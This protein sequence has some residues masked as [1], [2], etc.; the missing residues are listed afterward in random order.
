MA[1]IYHDILVNPWLWF[2]SIS[3]IILIGAYI[4]NLIIRGILYLFERRLEKRS[5]VI[6]IIYNSIKAPTKLSV[7][8]LAAWLIA[9]QYIKVDDI[10]F[11]KITDP[12]VLIMKLGFAVAFMWA[13]FRFANQLRDYYIDK[14]RRTDGGY[15]DFSLI[16]ALHKMG[17][18]AVTVV[19]FF[20]FMSIL[21]IPLGSL[22]VVS[23]AAIAFF[24]FSQQALIQNLFGGL[25]LYLDRPFSEGDWITAM[26][27]SF[28]GTVDKVSFRITRFI[29]FDSRP[30]Y[31]PNSFFLSKGIINNNRMGNR[32]I[33]QYITVRYQDFDKLEAILASIRTYLQ[34]HPRINKERT[35]LVNVVNGGTN[36]GP[37]SEGLYGQ[38]GV[39]FMIYTFTDQTNWVEFQNIQDDVMINIG[40]IIK[41][42]GAMLATPVQ[43]IQFS[44]N[45]VQHLV[46][47]SQTLRS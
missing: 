12:S 8:I 31:I 17:Q 28:E 13:L 27:G 47:A 1:Q 2:F 4:T 21:K 25:V 18:V 43:N 41:S 14:N 16:N 40:K 39:N 30:F 15:N 3:V 26:D 11:T 7:W 5:F 35:T 23:S 10:K 6:A 36:I 32:R 45:E 24:A 38:N 9:Q 29:G 42:H 46:Q 33:L 37:R 44:E 22:A 20:I 19:M 34:Q